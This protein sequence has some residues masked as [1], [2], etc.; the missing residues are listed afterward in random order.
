MIN[1]KIEKDYIVEINYSKNPRK[2]FCKSCS[3][4]IYEIDAI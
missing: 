1:V 4:L 2:V 3:G